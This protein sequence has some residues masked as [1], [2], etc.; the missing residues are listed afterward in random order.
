MER[1][2]LVDVQELSKYLGISVNAIY[3]FTSEKSSNDTI[4]A[5]K[6]G[7]RVRFRISEV[8]VWLETKAK[9][10]ATENGDLTPESSL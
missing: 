10:K 9:G 1:E 5:Y 2:Q 6:I 8:N 4:P 7:Q 3:R